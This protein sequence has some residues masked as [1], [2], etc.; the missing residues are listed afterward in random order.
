M[1]GAQLLPIGQ[2]ISYMIITS[3]A[4]YEWEAEFHKSAAKN[5]RK[6]KCGVAWQQRSETNVW[7]KGEL[8]GESNSSPLNLY[9]T[10]IPLS[11]NATEASLTGQAEW[12]SLNEDMREF[13]RPNRKTVISATLGT[14]VYA[15]GG[16]GGSG[17]DV[18]YAGHISTVQT[19]TFWDLGGKCKK[20]PMLTRH[21]TKRPKYFHIQSVPSHSC[22]YKD[23]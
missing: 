22:C 13:Q 1:C 5:R 10:R 18:F 14:L 7:Q 23:N 3:A 9:G 19:N 20:S 15:A 2:L 21:N 4:M 12:T 11:R 17:R 6:S 8:E 16:K